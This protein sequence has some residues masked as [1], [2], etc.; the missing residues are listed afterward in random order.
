MRLKCRRDGV[1]IGALLIGEALPGLG[2]ICYLE[3]GSEPIVQRAMR[4]ELC[5]LRGHLLFRKH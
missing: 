3:A 5:Y 1:V 4:R 2:E